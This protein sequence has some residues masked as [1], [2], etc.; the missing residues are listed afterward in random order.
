ML[1]IVE[2]DIAYNSPKDELLP[3]KVERLFYSLSFQ[4]KVLGCFWPPLLQLLAIKAQEKCLVHASQ[5][6]GVSSTLMLYLAFLGNQGA[7]GCP[8]DTEVWSMFDNRHGKQLY[9]EKQKKTS[10]ACIEKQKCPG[11]GCLSPVLAWDISLNV[12]PSQLMITTG[13]VR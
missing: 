9:F 13:M 2:F 3:N 5:K 8:C 1:L 4:C 10:L 6:S 12:L 11:D 7:W